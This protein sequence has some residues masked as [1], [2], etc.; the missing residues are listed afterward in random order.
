M[1]RFEDLK[2]YFDPPLALGLIADVTAER[3]A[4][5]AP[6]DV[7]DPRKVASEVQALRSSSDPLDKATRAL[8]IAFL[9]DGMLAK[10][11]AYELV[12]EALDAL[13]GDASLVA[14]EHLS[15]SGRS[16]GKSSC[17][18]STAAKWIGISRRHRFAGRP[19]DEVEL[20]STAGARRV[21]GVLV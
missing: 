3:A 16:S 4:S 5:L 18:T 12:G 20:V 2:G 9:Y 19:S 21:G 10:D 17:F 1:T 15:S 6:F 13:K 11:A 14:E 8:A 7:P